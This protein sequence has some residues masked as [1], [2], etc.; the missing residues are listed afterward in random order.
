MSSYRYLSTH[1]TYAKT[2]WPSHTAANVTYLI[3]RALIHREYVCF[4]FPPPTSCSRVFLELVFEQKFP[5][6]IILM[7]NLT[8]VLLPQNTYVKSCHVA[9]PP[10]LE[11]LGTVSIV[12]SGLCTHCEVQTNWAGGFS[13]G[14]WK[15]REFKWTLLGS[16]PPP[17]FPNHSTPYT[18]AVLRFW[19][20][21]KHFP[22]KVFTQLEWKIEWFFF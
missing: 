3:R 9:T 10:S 15:V 19:V 4:R 17:P 16:Q 7:N 20:A 12:R 18:A 14:E 21:L 22:L 2:Q 6:P 11:Q 1:N 13:F 8:Y 5:V